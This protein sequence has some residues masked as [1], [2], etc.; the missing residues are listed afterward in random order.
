MDGSG[1]LNQQ[2]VIITSAQAQSLFQGHQYGTN[3]AYPNG[4]FRAITDNL[5]GTQNYF[6]DGVTGSNTMFSVRADG[7][8]YF[9]GN[10]ALGNNINPA[11]YGNYASI[12]ADNIYG[13]LIDFTQK[14][15]RMG[16]VYGDG[17]GLT[18]MATT[19]LP[20]HFFSNYVESMTLLSNGNLGI[21]ITAPVAQL[22]VNGSFVT[23]GSQGNGNIE[24]TGKNADISYLKNTGRLLIG[25]NR[26]SGEGET[27]FISNRGKLGSLGGFAFYD[28]NN[29]NAQTEL[30]RIR[31]TG[32]V[33]IGVSNFGTSQAYVSGTN[34][35]SV[36]GG[37]E[38]DQVT[39]KLQTAWPDYVFKPDYKL[40][41]L[42]QVKAY[43][44]QN[45][46]LPDMP[47]EADIAKNG[48]NLGEMNKLLLT[49]VEEL[50]LYMMDANKK[51]N[52]EEAEIKAQNEKIKHLEE[53]VEQILKKGK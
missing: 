16:S 7:R 50:T 49:K 18:L 3:Y 9:A 45:R 31:S 11:V 24:T 43:I 39:V 4:M 53:A 35:L 48:Q 26:T 28:Y 10:M 14:G 29:S 47:S 25:F 37:I 17:T 32:Q 40:Q 6:Y 41:P 27:D 13:G 5:T 22:D 51:L 34:M 36:A 46:H 30:M 20:I 44:D 12:T 38:A 1:N 21:N 19:G 2:Q 42:S 8:G 15:T 52:A 23:G 33:L